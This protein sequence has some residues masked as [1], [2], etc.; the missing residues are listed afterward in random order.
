MNDELIKTW[1]FHNKDS[2]VWVRQGAQ[3]KITML[4]QSAS[5]NYGINAT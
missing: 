2:K 4:G 5:A 3:D 1:I